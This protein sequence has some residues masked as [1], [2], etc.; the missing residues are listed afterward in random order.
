MELLE[1][2]VENL[3]KELRLSELFFSKIII[4]IKLQKFKILFW[5]FRDYQR[6]IGC[7]HKSQGFEHK[8]GW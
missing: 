4:I 6:F 7:P 2:T 5:D 3:T 8:I 1:I